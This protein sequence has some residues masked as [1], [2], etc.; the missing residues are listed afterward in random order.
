MQARRWCFTINNP[1][2]GDNPL[3]LNG[4]EHIRYGIYQR[5]RGENGTEHLQGYIEFDTPMRLDRIK[6]LEGEVDKDVFKT[7]T[8]SSSSSR[9]G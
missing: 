7:N 2:E 6:R 9:N 8:S 4:I 3:D 5:E 1:P